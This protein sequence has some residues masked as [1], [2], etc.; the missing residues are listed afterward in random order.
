[1]IIYVCVR[2]CVEWSARVRSMVAAFCAERAI[3]LMLGRKRWE[4]LEKNLCGAKDSQKSL[5]SSAI[6]EFS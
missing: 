4:K 3:D 2:V 6:I 5:K 1:M